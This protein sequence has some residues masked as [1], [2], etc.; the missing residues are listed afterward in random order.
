M[1]IYRKG[2]QLAIQWFPHLY[3]EIDPISDWHYNQHLDVMVMWELQT[4]W[5][6]L[7]EANSQHPL[8]VIE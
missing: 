7:T 1:Q 6:A 3:L 8:L 4:P 2:F 5:A